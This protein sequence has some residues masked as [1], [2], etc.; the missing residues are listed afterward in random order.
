MQTLLEALVAVTVPLLVVVLPL[1]LA[2]WALARRA[3]RRAQCVTRQI[4]VTDAIH[5]E[6]GPVVAPFIRR[7]LWG[8][9][10]L[11]MAVPFGRPAVVGTA[12]AIAHQTL[13]AE[14]RGRPDA[15]QIVLTPQEKVSRAGGR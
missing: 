15:F 8:P 5:R 10:R 14:G 12:L 2:S 4:M 9:W 7:P 3:E 13:A 1:V 6:L 11:E